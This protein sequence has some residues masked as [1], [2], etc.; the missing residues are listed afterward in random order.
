VYSK[1]EKAF[2]YSDADFSIDRVPLS[3]EDFQA[4]TLAADVL[5]QYK[6]ARVVQQ[7]EGLLDRLGRVVNHL[8]QPVNNKLIAFENMPYYKGREY[9]D[10]L[11]DAVTLKRP[12]AIRYKKFNR[13]EVRTHVFHPYFLKEYH[14]RWYVL[15]YS[16]AREAI[17]VLA[18]DRIE[19]V[20]LAP[21]SF[22]ENKDLKPKEYFQHTLGVTLGTG[23]VED[24]ELWF[25][26]YIAP[27]LKTQHIHHSQY[28]VRADDEGLVIALRLIPNP[29]L[30][31]LI[32]SYGAD[33]KVLKPL[34]LKESIGEI[35]RKA[36][37]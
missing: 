1:K 32:L 10:A 28:T 7:F 30:T 33:V 15:G 20:D 35:W 14:G 6:G 3:E 21:V 23:P 26:P 29:E 13:E 22:R 27:Y 37:V 16:E 9:F 2:H 24:I 12:L 31:Q 17:I 36:I 5:H 25:S 11:V 19:K 4:L 18:L 34:A 8:K